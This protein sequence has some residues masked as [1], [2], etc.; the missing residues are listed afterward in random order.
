MFLLK[1]GQG[2]GESFQ[3][4]QN[5]PT[6]T[7]TKIQVI[8]EESDDETTNTSNA[9]SNS[10]SSSFSSVLNVKI[11][12][13][14]TSKATE[15]IPN[16]TQSLILGASDKKP[17]DKYR[18]MVCGTY[19]IGQSNGY[20][21]VVYYICKYIGRKEDIQ[22]TIYGFQNYNQ[23]KGHQR[24]DIPASVT[25]HDA[26]AKED[27][28]R[29]GF[30]EK[31]IAQYLKEH[32]QDLVMIFNDPVITSSLVQNI[33]E[34][35]SLMERRQFKLV[36]YMDQVYPYQRKQYIELLNTYFDGIIA[37]TPYWR[38]TAR[39]LGIRNEI[40]IYFFPHGFDSE[41]YYPIPSNICRIY[42]QLSLDAF[43]ILNLNRNQPRKRWDHT[44]MALA[45]VI[46]RHQKLKKDSKSKNVR[47]IQLV[48]GTQAQGFWD[49]LEILENELRRRE[50]PKE[51]AS[52]YIF[53][54]PNAQQLTDKD[55]NVLY[56][57]C[58][59]GLNT[60]EGEGFGLCQFEH[61]ALMGPQVAPNIGGFKE[62][63]N[64]QNSILVEPKWNY[65]IDKQRDGIG[66][67]AEVGD[68]K[69]YADGIWRYYQNTSMLKRHGRKGREEILQHYRWE[70][71]VDVFYDVLKR[72]EKGPKVAMS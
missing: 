65:Y 63:L 11:N 69:E 40:P 58:D 53:I 62:F 13:K 5:V 61:L 66:G 54:V 32:P 15:G 9:T 56:N 43:L 21:R 48:I 17:G 50:L 30:G 45:E 1:K 2:L 68:P 72:F 52:E 26:L 23:T 12:P 33:V 22:L 59:I 39:S 29:N 41:T 19:P 64:A 44:M 28:R 60:C 67:L 3:S 20:S 57:A 49:T 4:S 6:T 71:M 46:E 16:L 70:S 51:L 38:D 35:M 25:L 8:E 36:S 55:I 24:N 14:L 27:P 10:L 7:R 18:V 47:P 37:F 42:H 34:N 31:E